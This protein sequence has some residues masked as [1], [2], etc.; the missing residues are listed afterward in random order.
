MYSK[1]FVFSEKEE[2]NTDCL[3]EEIRFKED[4]P[5]AG[6]YEIIVELSGSGEIYIFT[7]TGKLVYKQ[8]LIGKQPVSCI[9]SLNIC[10]IIP[11][12]MSCL[13]EKRSIDLRIHGKELVLNRICLKQVNCPTLYV[14]G[15]AG[16]KCGPEENGLEWG[17]I[18]PVY[19]GK[20]AAVS[21]HMNSGMTMSTFLMK[22]HYALIQ[23]HVKLGDYLM[24]Q[25]SRETNKMDDESNAAYRDGLARLIEETRARGAHPI[26]LTPIDT[27][28]KEDSLEI[29]RCDAEICRELGRSFRIPVVDIEGKNEKDVY[30]LAGLIVREYKRL[31]PRIKADAY[32]RLAGLFIERMDW[33]D[34]H[35]VS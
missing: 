15:D 27:S 16:A 26:L 12:G 28:R 33:L 32:S 4:V 25:F 11:K 2:V 14:A 6:N 13:Y 17:R 7:D 34:W 3:V 31:F 24:L 10:D 30:R 18:L 22:G 5:R 23:A 35:E 29:T 9:F 21:D 19:I 20:G 8:E 1:T